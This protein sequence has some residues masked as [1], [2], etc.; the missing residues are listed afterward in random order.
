[1][2]KILFE[3]EVCQMLN[4]PSIP[5]KTFKEINRSFKFGVA[6]T[7]LYG[8]RLAYAV[9]TYDSENDKEPR[10]IKTF[11]REQY[12]SVKEIFVVPDYMDNNVEETDLDE[13]SKKAAERLA[14]E[15]AELEEGE[16]GIVKETEELE[17]EGDWV[18]PSIHSRDEAE[19]F[20]RDYNKRNKIGGRIPKTDENIKLRLMTIYAE[21][22]D[23]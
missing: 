1:M 11:A 5:L 18:F 21:T 16:D 23:K 6:V 10:I 13:E 8:D 3:K 20:L 2:E 9:C 15:A 19:A 4:I 7:E 12:Y 14:Q 17:G 22:K